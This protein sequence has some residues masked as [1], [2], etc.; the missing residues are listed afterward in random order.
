MYLPPIYLL[1]TYLSTSPLPIYLSS[2]C[3]STYLSIYLS[4]YLSIHPYICLSLSIHPYICLS[5][6]IYLSIYLFRTDITV[7]VD[8]AL[9]TNNQSINL[10]IIYIYIYVSIYLPSCAS[11]STAYLEPFI[12]TKHRALPVTLM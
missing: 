2:I 1:S 11:H 10:S 8:W 12:K 3:I 5:L 6:S 4:T 9:K 7:M